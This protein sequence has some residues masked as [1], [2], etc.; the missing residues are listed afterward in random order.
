[1]TVFVDVLGQGPDLTL[2][3]GWGMNGAVWSG[4]REPLAAR[5]TLH[6]IDLPGHG[7]S[8]GVP[9]GTLDG[10]VDAVAHAMPA[11][12]HLL[13]WSLGGHA[14]MALAHRF[15]ARVGKLVS[16]SATPRFV[17]GDDWPHGKRPEVLADFAGRLSTSYLATIRN[18]LALQALHQPEMREVIRQLQEAIS[19]HGAPSVTSLAASLDIL[20]VSDIRV[21]VPEIA[22]PALV[23]QGDHDALTSTGAAQWLADHLPGSTY[24]LIEHAA[25]APFLSH[26]DIFLDHLLAFLAT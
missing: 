14:A 12:S 22:A 25:H 20:R 5:F 11:R 3:H 9:V 13:G 15:P 10:V 18:F 7:R 16:V 8:H 21:Q 24:C 1:V 2:L 19:A 23:I 17:A 4:I 26:R 6:I